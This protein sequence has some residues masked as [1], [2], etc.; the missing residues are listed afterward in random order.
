VP[1]AIAL[2]LV[3]T[4]WLLSW[5]TSLVI[6]YHNLRISGRTKQVLCDAVKF[7]R[8]CYSI[9]RSVLDKSTVPFHGQLGTTSGSAASACD[10]LL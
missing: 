5:A 8:R 9:A 2:L 1:I 6:V 3:G 10:F 7:T 4:F